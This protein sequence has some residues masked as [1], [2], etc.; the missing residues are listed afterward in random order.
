MAAIQSALGAYP[1]LGVTASAPSSLHDI[2]R[3]TTEVHLRYQ[4]ADYG[5]AARILPSLIRSVDGL[6]A[7]TRGAER[8]RALELPTC[9]ATYLS[10]A[11][12]RARNCVTTN[13]GSGTIRSAV[14]VLPPCTTSPLPL[15]G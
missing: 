7:E 12:R 14:A 5:A 3:M 9:P 1:G 13:C 8:R 11:L 4:S 10:S 2:A 15:T 6:V